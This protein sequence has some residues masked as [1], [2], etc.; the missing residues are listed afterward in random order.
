MALVTTAVGNT[1]RIVTTALNA[2]AQLMMTTDIA[3]TAVSLRHCCQWRQPQRHCRCHQLLLQST[4]TTMT[5][6]T[7]T[8]AAIA[9]ITTATI[10]LSS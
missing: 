10:T 4:R 8:I 3:T 1:G 6:T 5:M 9:A 7:T 2:Y